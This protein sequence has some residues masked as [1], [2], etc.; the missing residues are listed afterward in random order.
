MSH[1]LTKRKRRR[2]EEKKCCRNKIESGVRIRVVVS[3]ENKSIYS[4]EGVEK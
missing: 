2:E 4:E 1:V 3:S